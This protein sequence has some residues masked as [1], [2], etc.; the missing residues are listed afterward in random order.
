MAPRA[1]DAVAVAAPER[2]PQTL[3]TCCCCCWCCWW[4][5]G[6]LLLLALRPSCGAGDGGVVVWGLGG[7]GALLLVLPALPALLPVLRPPEA[8]LLVLPALLLGLRPPEPVA[9][10]AREVVA[11]AAP[12]HAVCPLAVAAP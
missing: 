9:P 7:V 1:S 11:L 5:C 3:C 4:P 10:Q 6:A 8:Q 2:T 12:Q